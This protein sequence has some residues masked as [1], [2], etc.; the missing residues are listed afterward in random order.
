MN[1][2]NPRGESLQ[3]ILPSLQTR[4]PD[5]QIRKIFFSEAIYVSQDNFKFVVRHKKTSLKVD[6]TL[7][8][9][10]ALGAILI[11]VVIVSLV[12]SLIYGQLM[13]GIGGALWI[14]LGML[15]MKYF[16][17]RV[18]KEQF[19]SFKNNLTDVVSGFDF[20]KKPAS[21]L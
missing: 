10:W 14:I 5:A 1:I 12:M 17:R 8:V 18:K 11:S 2:P 19:E 20:E 13:F 4:Y 7:P 16:F 15:I 3:Q 9:L 6:N 21:S